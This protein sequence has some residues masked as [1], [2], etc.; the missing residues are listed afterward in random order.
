MGYISST[1]KEEP[2][3]NIEKKTIIFLST[4]A[5]IFF[6]VSVFSMELKQKKLEA[7]EKKAHYVIGS[8]KIVK[9]ILNDAFENNK[10]KDFDHIK[11]IYE[12]INELEMNYTSLEN[13]D[14]DK[15]TKEE[16]EK[17]FKDIL[18]FHTRF[19]DFTAQKK[20][21]ESKNNSFQDQPKPNEK[22]QEEL[23]QDLL[24]A[25]KNKS[26]ELIL[27]KVEYLASSHTNEKINFPFS[28]NTE[29]LINKMSKKLQKI[30]DNNKKGFEQIFSGQTE[31]NIRTE[32]LSNPFFYYDQC[33]VI[34]DIMLTNKPPLTT[35]YVDF[36]KKFLNPMYNLIMKFLENNNIQKVINEKLNTAQQISTSEKERIEGAYNSIEKKY[37]KII[38]S[39]KEISLTPKEISLTPPISDTN[40]ISRW[41][42]ALFGGITCVAAGGVISYCYK[43]PS[44]F[45]RISQKDLSFSATLK[46]WWNR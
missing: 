13:E 17:A 31:V 19:N 23:L 39:K 22:S 46:S 4:V 25:G 34:A 6:T 33:I 7:N 43:N 30:L 16:L 45:E 15:E 11:N 37:A 21:I 24:S 28:L 41:R 27:N 14:L 40:Q 12:N 20:I 18:D 42:L 9:K 32:R 35:Y 5:V 26:L 36:R 8:L 10:E 29:K 3:N 2:L 38:D 1:R 44:L